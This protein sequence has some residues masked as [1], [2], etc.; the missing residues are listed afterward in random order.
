MFDVVNSS[1]YGR[2]LLKQEDVLKSKFV[3]DQASN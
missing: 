1:A 3:A 2:E